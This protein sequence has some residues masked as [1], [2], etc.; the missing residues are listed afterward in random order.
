MPA[1]LDKCR[2]RVVE[3]QLDLL[4][5]PPLVI[6]TTAFL[7]DRIFLHEMKLAR[8]TRLLDVNPALVVNEVFQCSA[9]LIGETG[10]HLGSR[11]R[12]LVG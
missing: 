10:K 7:L 11:H 3:L 8:L 12:R 2:L 9:R 5:L 6:A 4:D 1:K